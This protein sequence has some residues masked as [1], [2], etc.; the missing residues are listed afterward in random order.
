MALY[1]D[2]TS[3]AAGVRTNTV[4]VSPAEICSSAMGTAVSSQFLMTASVQQPTNTRPAVS[5]PKLQRW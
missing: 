4:T 2:W 5:F 1:L 3:N